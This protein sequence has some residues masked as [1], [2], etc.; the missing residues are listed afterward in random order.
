MQCAF[1]LMKTI[2]F[3]NTLVNYKFVCLVYSLFSVYDK[4]YYEDL[5]GESMKL[6]EFSKRIGLP[7]TKLRYY[8]RFGVTEPERAEN[9][10]RE[11]KKDEAIKIYN[12]LMMRSFDMKIEDIVDLH[13]TE[14]SV[15]VD[16]WVFGQ[17]NDI[18]SKIEQ[19]QIRLDRLKEL[20]KS[21]EQYQE[22]KGNPFVAPRFSEYVLW[23][24]EDDF[25]FNDEN[26]EMLRKMT[27]RC[28]FSYIAL[29]YKQEDINKD[30]FSPSLGIGVLKKNIEK[31]GLK[32]PENAEYTGDLQ[33][34][35][36]YFEN[37]RMFELTQ[38]DLKPLYELA[39]E[40]NVE[41]TGDL[42]GRFYMAYPKNGKLI[43]CYALG[44]E[45]RKK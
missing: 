6:N 1:N 30:V 42:T 40:M 21:I 18:Q 24:F 36:C 38:E 25:K 29:K 32:V 15:D 39:K 9:N 26:I 28:P 43:Y 31:C 14:K 7:V 8:A 45:Y 10:Y 23:S 22:Y 5:A 27:N 44:R 3:V 12:A 33:Y 37:D 13:N 41:L 11:F 35:G 34:I 2:F 20:K 17:L 19:L 16:S 4:A